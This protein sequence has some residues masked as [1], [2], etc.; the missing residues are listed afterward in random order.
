MH[1]ERNKPEE[2]ARAAGNIA[3]EGIPVGEIAARLG[4]ALAARGLAMGTAES[5]TGGLIAGALTDVPGASEWFA[6]AVVAYANEVKRDV[7]GVDAALLAAHGAVSGPVVA[8]MARGARRVLGVGAAVAVSGVAG[9]TGGTPQ[10]PVGTVWIGWSVGWSVGG[11][12]GGTGDGTNAGVE[13]AGTALR[14]FPGDR[15]AVRAQ[16]V[17]AALEELLHA[18]EV[19]GVPDPGA[20]DPDARDQQGGRG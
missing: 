6:G 10:K 12:P 17:R 19:P 16:T 13:R 9:P 1:D 8:A 7:L 11:I 5:C 3:T 2:A 15:A 4:R 20:Y 14:H 18:V